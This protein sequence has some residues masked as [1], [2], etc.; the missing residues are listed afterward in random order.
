[1]VCAQEVIEW[2]KGMRS[3]AANIQDLSWLAG[4]WKGKRNGFFIDELWTKPEGNNMTGSFRMIKEGEVLFSEIESITG[5]N[6]TLVLKIKHFGKDLKAWEEKD[7][8]E[9]FKL[10]KIGKKEAWFDRL[11]IKRKGKKLK[12]WVLSPDTGGHREIMYFSFKKARL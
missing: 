4:Y 6:G 2:K 8:M 11:T 7:E 9:T 12:I 5:V 1:M 10:L 3:P